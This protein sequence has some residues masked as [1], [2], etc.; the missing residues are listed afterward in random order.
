MDDSTTVVSSDSQGEFL[1]PWTL[2]KNGTESE[3]FN[4]NVSTALVNLMP[5]GATN[6]DR[7]SCKCFVLDLATVVMDDIEEKWKLLG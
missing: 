3:T 2:E 6:R 5:A 4:R 1:L 7:I